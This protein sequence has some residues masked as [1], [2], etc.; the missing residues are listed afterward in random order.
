MADSFDCWK[1]FLGA[2]MAETT[3]GQ[4]GWMTSEFA[5]LMRKE[6]RRICVSVA[7]AAA[8]DL[9]A[10]F[11]FPAKVKDMYYWAA[12]FARLVVG[13]RARLE[14]LKLSVGT[15][16]SARYFIKL[17]EFGMDNQDVIGILSI[18]DHDA[19]SRK[20]EEQIELMTRWV[21][22]FKLVADG[23]PPRLFDFSGF[24]PEPDV[25]GQEKDDTG[26]P[27]AMDEK[28]VAVFQPDDGRLVDVDIAALAHWLFPKAIADGRLSESDVEFLRLW[29]S[30][31]YF[32][33]APIP[34][35]FPYE[36][37]VADI[38]ERDLGRKIDVQG[39]HVQ[40]RYFKDLSVSYAGFRYRL[41]ATYMGARSLPAILN[42]FVQRGYSEDELLKVCRM[43]MPDGG[44]RQDE[45][46]G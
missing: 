21:D 28:K 9:C 26:N 36:E 11:E 29:K 30:G 12:H 22:D 46:L 14:K 42:W 16:E 31:T 33:T 19:E 34:I 2:G 10:Q 27:V 13:T 8:D 23:P 24:D 37:K 43:F 15:D 32:Q 17:L 7:V 45:L 25:I 4:I 1:G 39:R 35:L 6:S 3:P 5:C 38:A 18:P 20:I 40:I 41:L 44:T